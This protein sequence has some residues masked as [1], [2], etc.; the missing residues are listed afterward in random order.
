MKILVLGAGV[1]GVTTAHA[2][3]RLGHEVLVIDRGDAVASQASQANGAQLAYSYV[4]P[5]ANS[6]TFKK[7]PKYMLG[8]DEGISLGL[9]RKFAYYAWGLEFIRHCTP[10]KAVENM[11]IMLELA[12]SSKQAMSQICTEIPDAT[13]RAYGAGKIILARTPQELEKL[14]KTVTLKKSYGFDVKILDKKNCIIHEPSLKF[15]QGEFCGGIYAPGDKVLDPLLFCLALQAHSESKYDV[16]YH[17]GHTIL[18]LKQANNKIT[19]VQTDKNIFNCDAVIVCLGEGANKILKTIDKAYPIYPMRGYSL[20]L[21]AGK[22]A[23]KTSITD[24]L[25]KIVV[26]NLGGKIRI[27]GFLDA[28]MSEAKIGS[29]EQALLA[30]ARKLWPSVAQYDGDIDFWSGLRPMTPS[31]IPIVKKSKINGLYYNIGHGSL[32]LTLATGSAQR[33]VQLIEGAPQNSGALI[34]E[35]NHEF[36]K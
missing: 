35:E 7:I 26:S 11:Q 24:P 9:T 23:I 16:R 18:K 33:I 3:S 5:F 29:R 6:T 14:G 28:N 25:S 21:P 20:T 32:G 27:A 19:Q 30:T 34:R 12:R 22:H 1:I 13:I 31:G 15:W 4:D 10:K 17:F 36:A 8:F 2:L